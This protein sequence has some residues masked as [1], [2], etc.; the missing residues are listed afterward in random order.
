MKFS[1]KTGAILFA[2]I[3]V[4]VGAAIVGANRLEEK[5]IANAI[6]K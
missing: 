1:L 2:I 3:L 5:R 6:G 4:G